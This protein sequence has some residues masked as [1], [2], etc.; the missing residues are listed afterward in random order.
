MN[1]NVKV[2]GFWASRWGFIL[3]ASGSAVGLGNI[4]KFPYI[5][6]QNGGGAF[7]LVYLLCVLLVGL[8]I[9][10]AEFILGRKTHLNPVGAFDQLKPNSPWIGI[11]YMGVLGGFLILSFYGVVGGWTYAYVVKSIS[12]SVLAF[13]SPK[14][15]GAF[16]GSFIGNTGEVLFYHALFMGTCIAIVLRGVHGDLHR[17]RL[18]R[19][20]WRH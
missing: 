19:R 16:F 20:A 11:G 17:H 4:W 8:P 3:A 10:L 5:T 18:K 9:M 1:G 14:E 6:G 2:R 12:G 13:P 7:V 15:A